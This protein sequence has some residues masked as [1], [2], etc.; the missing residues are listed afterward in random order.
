MATIREAPSTETQINDAITKAAVLKM[1]PQYYI[2]SVIIR[3]HLDREIV[4][5]TIG[6]RGGGKSGTDAVLGVVAFMMRGK[7]VWSNMLW[8]TLQ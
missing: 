7:K 2:D 6:D 5:G 1:I 3:E 8:V 4:L